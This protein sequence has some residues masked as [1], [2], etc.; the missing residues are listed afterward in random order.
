MIDIFEYIYDNL[1]KYK[2]KYYNQYHSKNIKI[3]INTDV[4]ML[5]KDDFIN[6][7]SVEDNTN[8]LTDSDIVIINNFLK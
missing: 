3:N 2:N 4:F 5:P 6:A 1:L 7:I 8:K